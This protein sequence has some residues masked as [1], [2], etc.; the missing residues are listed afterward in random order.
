MCAH[1][2]A[3]AHSRWTRES[4]LARAQPLHSK[5][6][7]ESVSRVCRFGSIYATIFPFQSAISVIHIVTANIEC[8]AVL[9]LFVLQNYTA[10]NLSRCC[11]LR[12]PRLSLY[13][14]RCVYFSCNFYFFFFVDEFILFWPFV[15]C[16]DHLRNRST[17]QFILN[18]IRDMT[19]SEHTFVS[20]LLVYLYRMVFMVWEIKVHWM[21]FE[22]I[23]CYFQVE[24]IS[25]CCFE[26]WLWIWIEVDAGIYAF[27]KGD[28]R[29]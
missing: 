10:G 2:G 16:D 29:L 26:Q 5:F 14:S 3:I 1:I 19:R 6:R 22:R 13:C 15:E 4:A 11:T 8:I 12:A 20:Y 7:H 25:W 21:Y 27:I 24:N 17:I 9:V 23:K 28:K 18:D